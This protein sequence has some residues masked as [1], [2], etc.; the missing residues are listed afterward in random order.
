M[1]LLPK[2]LR[3]ARFGAGLFFVVQD[4]LGKTAY[5]TVLV[6]YAEVK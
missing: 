2:N 6:I 3:P 4:F 5:M 1:V